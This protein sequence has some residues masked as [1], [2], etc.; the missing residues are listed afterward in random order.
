MIGQQLSGGVN[1]RVQIGALFRGLELREFRAQQRQVRTK[2]WKRRLRRGIGDDQIRHVA[3]LA[4]GI[5]RAIRRATQMFE[6]REPALR[7]PGRSADVD[8]QHD[9]SGFAGRGGFGRRGV[10]PNRA[11]ERQHNAGGRQESQQQ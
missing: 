1:R 6:R 10:E 4:Q 9:G 5:E 3:P 8:N 11:R 7:L 2:P